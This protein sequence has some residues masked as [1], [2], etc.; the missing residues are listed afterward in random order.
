M[1]ILFYFTP[2]WHE[3]KYAPEVCCLTSGAYKILANN[4]TGISIL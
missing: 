4:Y 1:H 2:T 3:N